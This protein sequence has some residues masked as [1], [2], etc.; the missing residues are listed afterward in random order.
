MYAV[1]ITRTAMPRS[2]D[3]NKSEAAI[4]SSLAATPLR[5]NSAWLDPR[6]LTI[7]VFQLAISHKAAFCDRTKLANH[8]P[9]EPVTLSLHFSFVVVM[10]GWERKKRVLKMHR[11]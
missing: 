5:Q 8:M 7:G 11:D 3:A 2:R 9:V 10:E 6:R 1:G 4:I